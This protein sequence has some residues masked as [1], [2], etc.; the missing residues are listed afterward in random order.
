MGMEGRGR[1]GSC[2]GLVQE[3]GVGF[4][5]REFFAFEVEDF[6]G[7]CTG[8]TIR[9]VSVTLTRG[10]GMNLHCKYGKMFVGTRGA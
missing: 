1:D 9:L 3:A 10:K 5:T 2:A 7:V 8:T 6:D 4:Y